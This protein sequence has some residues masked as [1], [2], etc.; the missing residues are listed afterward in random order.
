MFPPGIGRTH[1]IRKAAD[2]E[3]GKLLAAGVLEQIKDAENTE[4]FGKMAPNKKTVKPT[5]DSH[6][7]NYALVNYESKQQVVDEHQEVENNYENN[8]FSFE[9]LHW[10]DC[11]EIILVGAAALFVLRYI[12]KY[13]KKRRQREESARQAQL[14]ST[15]QDSIPMTSIP[16]APMVPMLEDRSAQNNNKGASRASSFRLYQP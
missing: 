9:R 14:V 2:E 15:L 7:S 11:L 6:N 3:L 12:Q 8:T 10:T 16:T 13:M 1:E 5:S 4:P